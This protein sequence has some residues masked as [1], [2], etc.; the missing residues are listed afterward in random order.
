M[1]SNTDNSAMNQYGQQGFLEY[2]DKDDS[3][4]MVRI[5]TSKG[6]KPLVA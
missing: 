2:V 3:L 1:L 4:I 6:K 5:I